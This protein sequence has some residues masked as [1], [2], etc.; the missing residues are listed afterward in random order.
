MSLPNFIKANNIPIG[1]EEPHGIFYDI[2]QRV[3]DILSFVS[4]TTNKERLG[5][6][7]S[8]IQPGGSFSSQNNEDT[9][10]KIDFKNRFIHPTHYSLKGYYR[11]YFAQEWN[12]YGYN[13]PDKIDLIA[14]NASIES[15]YCGDPM[16]CTSCI[17][18]CCNDE[19]GTF[20]MNKVKEG[21]RYL[22]IKSKV[23]SSKSNWHVAL[24]GLEIFGIL[25]NA[26]S[27]YKTK[28][29]KRIH[30]FEFIRLFVTYLFCKYP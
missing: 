26:K 30:S 7:S 16:K 9:H 8:I 25:S 27:Y 6:V 29:I 10:I 15:T 3:S 23:P 1:N 20:S 19:W 22:L 11:A 2:R 13:S 17:E 28:M 12:I 21:Y 18:C 4:V 14:T 24:R 5:D